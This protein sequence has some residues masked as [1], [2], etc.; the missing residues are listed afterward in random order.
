ME[1]VT[2]L[3]KKLSVCG[4]DERIRYPHVTHGRKVP[5]ANASII[6]NSMSYSALPERGAAFHLQQGGMYRISYAVGS[7]QHRRVTRSLVVFEGASQRRLWGGQLVGCLDFSRP[8][9]R[10]LSLLSAQLVDVRPATVNE[11]GQLVLTDDPAQR[12]RRVSRRPSLVEQ[13]SW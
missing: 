11:R 4:D 12:K 2:G 9:G 6:A 1:T 10:P 5:A 3:P 8:Q 7:S 13:P